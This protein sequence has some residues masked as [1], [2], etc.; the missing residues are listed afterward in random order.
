MARQ[1]SGFQRFWAAIGAYGNLQTIWQLA[2]AFGITRWHATVMEGDWNEPHQWLILGTWFFGTWAVLATVTL[3]LRKSGPIILRL[4]DPPEITI[5]HAGGL[6]AVIK[7]K[8]SGQP[9]MYCAEGQIVQ[10]N[11]NS[12]NLRPGLFPCVLLSPTG[13]S[14]LSLRMNDGEWVRIVLA[15]IEG[16]DRYDPSPYLAIRHDPN[17]HPSVRVPDSGV[18]V[19]VTIRP[20]PQLR[21]EIQV[22][23]YR[24]SRNPHANL[25]DIAITEEPVQ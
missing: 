2:V 21:S 13:Q 1:E 16:A 10:M 15:A 5:T 23:R 4:F 18:I 7:M 12:P 3:G 17:R 24:I 6:E 19:E 22:R 14:Y 11:D 25:W 8:H 20:T 9:T